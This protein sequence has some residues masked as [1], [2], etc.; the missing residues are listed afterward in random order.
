MGTAADLVTFSLIEAA[1]IIRQ[2][3]LKLPLLLSIVA[4]VVNRVRA[5]PD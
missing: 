2:M 1:A 3:P 4:A 5:L